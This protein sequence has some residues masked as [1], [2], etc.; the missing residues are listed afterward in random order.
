MTTL[1]RLHALAR[2]AGLDHEGLRDLMRARWPGKE[3]LADLDGNDLEIFERLLHRRV[4]GTPKRQA[5]RG[6]ARPEGVVPVASPPQRRFLAKLLW[7]LAGSQPDGLPAA[8][9]FARRVLGEQL[10]LSHP[11]HR[12]E[13]IA[14]AVLTGPDASLLINA[15]IGELKR[16]NLWDERRIDK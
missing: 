16:R 3:S 1:R 4:G 7:R 11:A 5:P 10:R 6:R 12:A 13:E 8:E 15:A 14:Q 9:Q 2:R